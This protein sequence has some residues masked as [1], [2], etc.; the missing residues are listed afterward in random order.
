MEFIV[1]GKSIHA[2]KAILT[3]RCEHFRT[4]FSGDWQETRN[5]LVQDLVMASWLVSQLFYDLVCFLL[6]RKVEIPFSYEVFHAFIV[7]VYT[8][9][10]NIKLDHVVGKLCHSV[11]FCSMNNNK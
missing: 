1:S 8:D 3:L 5:G 9:E 7:Y 11:I 2:H 4:M 10:I 6:C